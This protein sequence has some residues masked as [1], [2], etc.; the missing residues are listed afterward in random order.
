MTIT[1]A[2]LRD[3]SDDA[4]F[5][6]L[7]FV[8]MRD[9]EVLVRIVGAGICHTDLTAR[10]PAY[11]IQ[12]PL[13]LGHEG[14]GIVEKIGAKVTRVVPGDHV[15]LSFGY[16]GACP[17]CDAGAPYACHGFGAR[18]MSG[19]RHDGSTSGRSNGEEVRSHFFGQSSF[20]SHS[21]VNELSTIKVREDAPLEMLG[22]LG[23]GVQTGAGTVM[24]VF[25]PKAGEAIVIFGG[26][27][28]GLSALMAA[29]VEGC[30]P[31]ILVEP[32]PARRT[33]GLE[34]GAT[35]AVDPMA[36]DVVT[37]VQEITGGPGALYAIDTAGPPKVLEQA[38]A[39]L[40]PRGQLALLTLA[41]H[42]QV[43]PVAI[44]DMLG[45]S[46]TI[47]GVVEGRSDIGF[48]PKL[49]DLIMA[50]KFPLEKLVRY[51]DFAEINA[52]FHDQETGKTVKPIIRMAG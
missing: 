29:V 23:C 16:C 52:A 11:A 17:S 32:N 20:A 47:H 25:K 42:D 51:Y 26:G 2:V 22:P 40:A 4:R 24:N 13:V 19:C 39:S 30:S 43:L 31:I 8:D 6:E 48:I 7:D 14:A 38:I 1:A 9:D 49:V 5:E 46:L 41:S 10:T 37:R 18:N 12:R 44:M 36:E 27:G 34:L 35:V 28:V 3:G 33:L 15:V 21:I 45:K 50:G